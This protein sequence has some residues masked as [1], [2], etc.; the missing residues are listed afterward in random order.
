[1]RMAVE[2]CLTA[3]AQRREEDKGHAQQ[4]RAQRLD[5]IVATIPCLLAAMGS[6]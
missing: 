1:V 2:V 6:H 5:L 3:K 4:G